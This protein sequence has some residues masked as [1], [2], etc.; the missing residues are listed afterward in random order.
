MVNRDD[1]I[2][3]CLGCGH[4]YAMAVAIADAFFGNPHWTLTDAV[5]YV[6]G[7]DRLP[8]QRPCDH[9]LF[10]D[11]ARQADLVDACRAQKP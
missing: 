7:L 4:S 6:R 5:C 9:G 1:V 10:G 2:R 11:D 3:I 8:E